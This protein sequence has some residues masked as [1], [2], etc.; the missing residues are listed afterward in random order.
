ML[1]SF[2][3]VFPDGVPNERMIVQ[4]CTVLCTLCSFVQYSVQLYPYTRPNLGVLYSIPIRVPT[5]RPELGVLYSVRIRVPNWRPKIGI[6]IRVPNELFI[7][8]LFSGGP[9]CTF[10][11]TLYRGGCTECCTY[12]SQLGVPNWGVL[13]SLV[14][15][16]VVYRRPEWRYCVVLVYSIGFCIVF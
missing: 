5:W 7:K 10:W 11:C 6:P 15:R 16:M 1:Y 3:F 4:F 9:G 2:D 13:Y 8:V 12:A 14:Y